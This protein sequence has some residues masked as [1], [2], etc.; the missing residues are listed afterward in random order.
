MIRFAHLADL[1]LGGWR[2]KT[3]TQLNFETFIRAIDDI[4][5][6]KVDF[7][8]FAGDIFNSAVPPLDLVQKV[9]EQL[10]R[11]KKENISLY[12]IGGSH[13]YSST[14][15]SFINLLGAADLFIDVGRWEYVDHNEVELK[16]TWHNK[17]VVLAGIVGKRN[18]LDKV[19][20][21]NISQ[22]SLPEEAYK[23]F[24]FHTTL[25]D[26]KPDF[27]KNYN[28]QVT[29]NYLPKGF[30]YYA[31][32]HVHTFIDSTYNNAPLSYPGPLFPNSIS[33]FKRETPSYNICSFDGKTTTI[34]RQFL[35]TYI[36]E[37]IEV[38]VHKEN[39]VQVKDKILEKITNQEIEGKIILLEIKGV[40]EGLVSDIGL[41]DAT[42]KLYGLGALQVLKHTYNLSST[43]IDIFEEDLPL[44]IS[45]EDIEKTVLD[46]FL[47]EKDLEKNWMNSLLSLDLEKQEEEKNH[48]Y[49]TRVKEAIEKCL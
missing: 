43:K 18:G 41:I 44:E 46:D 40:V 2:E 1:H 38:E 23:I 36:F 21:K 30:N 4:I 7:A 48:H 12:V 42:K 22:Q 11:L 24:I 39:P 47:K 49:E 9:V 14:G 28:T 8:I 25:N 31:G 10:M 29:S 15:K 13:D 45:I 26:I 20:Y 27:L 32:G 3:L 35:P 6:K 33:E 5:D 37:S 34:E 17:D 19:M 16:L